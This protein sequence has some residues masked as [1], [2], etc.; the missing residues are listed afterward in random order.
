M[1]TSQLGNIGEVNTLRILVEHNI[2]VYTSFGD[3]NEVDLIAIINNKCVKI[4][5]KTTEKIHN[6]TLMVWKLGKQVGFHGSKVPYDEQSI[7][8][9]ALYCIENNTLCFVP[10]VKGMAMQYSAIS[11]FFFSSCFCRSSIICSIS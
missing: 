10:N 9:F 8:Y 2:P 7:D 1:N 3:G 6:N 11:F 4:Q 5:V